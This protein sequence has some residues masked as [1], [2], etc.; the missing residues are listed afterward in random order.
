[1][2]L[3]EDWWKIYAKNALYENWGSMGTGVVRRMG[4][5]NGLHGAGILRELGWIRT[6]LDENWVG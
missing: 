6:G 1:L 4:M 3:N 5:R 2:G